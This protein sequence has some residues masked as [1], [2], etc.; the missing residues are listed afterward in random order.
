MDSERHAAV[1]GKAKYPIHEDLL[2]SKALSGTMDASGG[3]LSQAYV[4]GCDC[5]DALPG[6][7]AP[8][9]QACPGHAAIAGACATVLKAL[10]EETALVSGVVT[11]GDDGK[12]LLPATGP[13]LTIGGEI[14]K[15]AF[16]VPMGRN[17]AGIHYRS[18]LD[19]GLAL[20]GGSGYCVYAGQRG[21]FHGEFSGIRI[22]RV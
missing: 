15:L 10:F 16:N 21:G 8:H 18:D 20:G 1:S 2:N 7:L 11:P 5:G 14:T 6:G 22:Y 9:G 12:S 13:A 19:A 3:L 4:E 17:W